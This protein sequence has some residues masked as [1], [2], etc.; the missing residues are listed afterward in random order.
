MLPLLPNTHLSQ[1]EIKR[2]EDIVTG[3]R[4]RLGEELQRPDCI[5]DDHVSRDQLGQA[6]ERERHRVGSYFG[7][8]LEELERKEEELCVERQK[9]ADRDQELASR[10]GQRSAEETELGKA[11][12]DKDAIIATL[13]QEL[14]TATTTA[15]G[16]QCE[17][18]TLQQDKLNLESR[19]NGT[20]ATLRQEKLDLETTHAGKVSELEGRI[21]TVEREKSAIEATCENT[22]GQLNVQ[23]SDLLQ[24]VQDLN[25]R[26]LVLQQQTPRSNGVT[27]TSTASSQQQVPD[28]NGVPQAS[29]DRMD[30]DSANAVFTAPPSASS[31]PNN[32]SGE[33]ASTS[34]DP[35][36]VDPTNKSA[37]QTGQ[38]PSQP[39]LDPVEAWRKLQGTKLLA[40]L[41]GSIGIASSSTPASMANH[42]SAAPPLAT[43][44]TS[45]PLAQNSQVNSAP[46]SQ[47]QG[48]TTSSA[49]TTQPLNNFTPSASW[50]T[51]PPS[52]EIPAQ[53]PRPGPALPR[54]T[55]LP[56][57]N[58]FGNVPVFGAMSTESFVFNPIA[59]AQNSASASVQ[60]SQQPPAPP[61]GQDS[62]PQPSDSPQPNGLQVE[63]ARQESSAVTT[64]E[65]GKGK[66]KE[67]GSTV[68]SQSD[69]LSQM[70]ADVPLLSENGEGKA[71]E[72]LPAPQIN[73]TANR[74]TNGTSSHA[75][76]PPS[77]SPSSGSPSSNT[78]PTPLALQDKSGDEVVS[79][80]V[81]W[82]GP[83]QGIISRWKRNLRA[84]KKEDCN[85]VDQVARAIGPWLHGKSQPDDLVD[86]VLRETSL[87]LWAFKIHAFV[88][89][90]SFRGL[91]DD[92]MR[93][94]KLVLA[95]DQARR[96]NDSENFSLVRPAV[97]D[98]QAVTN[99]VKRFLFG[100]LRPLFAYWT[101]QFARTNMQI[102][103]MEHTLAHILDW[104]QS[105]LVVDAEKT[106][107][108]STLPELVDFTN[109]LDQYCQ[110]QRQALL[111]GEKD[112]LEPLSAFIT[113]VKRYAP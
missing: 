10:P 70:P 24:Q 32:A 81:R 111:T 28:P 20:I 52:D 49:A 82:V 97:M 85:K 68:G 54:P 4:N 38:Q 26:V 7:N 96:R 100:S 50:F 2:L 36:D 89:K 56:T 87:F 47:S 98:P 34:E 79:L 69:L 92:T 5:R 43:A 53:R 71:K 95:H 58:V 40:D 45:T 88:A 91:S 33:A 108:L 60:N 84:D 29:E 74:V 23:I 66:E 112:L 9:V 46:P 83:Q 19:L 12:A 76:P 102:D 59:Q 30:V 17:V 18:Q 65:K 14:A 109:E 8:V 80:I 113:A 94:V 35:M 93:V 64:L 77:A 99:T 39:H 107:F 110:D 57:L 41:L 22:K 104:L 15:N 103:S 42:G 13:R 73:T 27:S 86:K 51:P 90:Y 75:V 1:L 78:P 25:L 72:V 11:V 21:S 101:K 6:V 61:T 3:L 48:Q 67:D 62:I 106:V 55:P 63:Q 105:D 31:Q 16:L 44:S 37:Q